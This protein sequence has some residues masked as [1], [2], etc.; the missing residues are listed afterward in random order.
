MTLWCRERR[1]AGGV[2]RGL[3]DPTRIMSGGKEIVS[4][5]GTDYGAQISGGT[6]LVFGLASGATAFP[7][8]Q[9]VGSGGTAINTI[10]SGGSLIVSAGGTDIVQSGAAVSNV[11]VLKGGTLELVGGN[12]TPPKLSAGTILALG[13]AAVLSGY[14]VSSGI[15]LKVLSGG[16]DIGATISNGG[17]AIVTSGGTDSGTTILKGGTD[18]VFGGEIADDAAV[19]SGGLLVVYMRGARRSDAHHERRPGDGQRPWHRLWRTDLGWHAA[20]FWL[21]QRRDSIQRRAGCRVRWYG[22]RHD[23]CRR[24]L[25]RQRRR[26]GH[27][28]VRSVGGQ[29]DRAQRRHAGAGWRQHD[30]A[31]AVGGR[32]TGAGFRRGP[33]PLHRKQRYRAESYCREAP[34]SVPRSATVAS[35]L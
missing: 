32:D 33:H 14:T 20:Y 16:A 6:Q 28:A 1:R 29:R 4:A 18:V 15:T 17:T 11:T 10:F 19:S 2:L 30:P 23:L 21:G 7:G 9:V 5:N 13:S 31:Q 22:D 26:H 27:R 12:T 35:P 34:T 8:A 25:D 3:A 24:Q